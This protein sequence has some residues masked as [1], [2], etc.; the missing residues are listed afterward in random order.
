M[1]THGHV[2]EVTRCQCYR[3]NVFAQP[4]PIPDIAQHVFDYFPIG[5]LVRYDGLP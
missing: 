1:T 4:R 3:H 5:S 2:V